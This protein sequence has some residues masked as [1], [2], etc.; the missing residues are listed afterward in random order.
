MKIYPSTLSKL[1]WWLLPV[2]IGCAVAAIGASDPACVVGHPPDAT[3]DHIRTI[4][5]STFFAHGIVL[6]VR[7]QLFHVGGATLVLRSFPL[8]A[9]VA[10]ATCSAD[11]A[12]SRLKRL[13]WA[14]EGEVQ[15]KYR[16]HNH[17]ALGVNVTVD[18]HLAKYEPVT[19]EFWDKATVG[20]HVKKTACDAFASL[21]GSRVLIVRGVVEP[22]R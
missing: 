3:L 10:I 22:V 21:N 4:A 18:G 1:A 11:G 16:S 5:L 12:E 17:G 15:E 8:M 9:A 13:Q 19:Q 14:F 2:S 6:F 20:D 7:Q